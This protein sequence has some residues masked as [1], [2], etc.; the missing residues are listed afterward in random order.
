M[1]SSDLD[2]LL[3]HLEKLGVVCQGTATESAPIHLPDIEAPECLHIQLTNACNQ[4]CPACYRSP[5]EDSLGLDLAQMIRLI[6][7]LASL[8]VC[9]LALGG[10][11]PLMSPHL[12]PIVR[13]ARNCGILPNITTNGSLITENLLHDLA[14]YVGEIRLSCQDHQMFCEAEWNSRIDKIRDSGIALGFNLIVTKSNL[15]SLQNILEQLAAQR[16]TSLV[17]L[18][19][20]PGLQNQEWYTQS[21]LD[22]HDCEYL[23]NILSGLDKRQFMPCLSL[24]CA[25]SFLFSS[26]SKEEILQRG[27]MGCAAGKRFCVVKWNGDVYPCSHLTGT[28][29]RLGSLH[30]SPFT[31]I[32]TQ[33][34]QNRDS[35]AIKLSGKCEPCEYRENCSGCRTIALYEGGDISSDDPACPLFVDNKHRRRSEEGAH[36]RVKK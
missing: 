4:K 10:G 5:D 26:L 9:Q 35:R 36:K 2:R 11:E 19:P 13:H 3:R 15:G 27:V 25:F 23:E 12:L 33:F 28:G 8:G 6:D 31:A 21:R 32:W 24:D 18:R 22:A 29:F 20:K 30:D 16:P 17:L 14:G 34:L 7:D 1:C